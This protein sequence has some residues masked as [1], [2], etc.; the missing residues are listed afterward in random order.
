MIRRQ[1]DKM[2]DP[3]AVEEQQVGAGVELAGGFP[4]QIRVG[5]L[6]DGAVD[7]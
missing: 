4:P 2:Y 5:Q 3:K 7:V 1:L 6:R